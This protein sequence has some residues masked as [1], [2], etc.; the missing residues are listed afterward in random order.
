MPGPT[1]L[2]QV[3]ARAGT[4][5]VSATTSATADRTFARAPTKCLTRERCRWYVGAVSAARCGRSLCRWYLN[6]RGTLTYDKGTAEWIATS[7]SLWTSWHCR[8]CP[9]IAGGNESSCQSFAVAASKREDDHQEKEPPVHRRCAF[10][11]A[12]RARHGRSAGG[13]RDWGG[14]GAPHRSTIRVCE[15][16][17]QHA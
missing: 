1:L 3:A 17:H 9:A 5:C 13:L 6:R 2:A 15:P 4:S 11:T 8:E 7:G 14:R 16:C 10:D 12:L